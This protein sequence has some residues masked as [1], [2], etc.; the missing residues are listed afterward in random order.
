MKK[1]RKNWCAL[2]VRVMQLNYIMYVTFIT[3]CRLKN[4]DRTRI[5]SGKLFSNIKWGEYFF[6]LLFCKVN[7]S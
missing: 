1:K 3:H 4:C 2:S 7:N 5:N 6:L